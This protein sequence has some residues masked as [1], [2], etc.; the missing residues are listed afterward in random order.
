[1]IKTVIFDFDG[2]IADTWEVIIKLLK[3]HRENLGLPE[4]TAEIVSDFRSKG[5][6]E[7]ILKYNFILL[8]LPFI[9]PKVQRML[10]DHIKEVKLFPEMKN[11]LNSLKSRGNK[12]GIL[13]T[14]TKE[15][16]ETFL[17]FHEINFFD[18]I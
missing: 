4:I 8:K 12:I 7:L 14:N 5:F 1:M 15:N 11:L 17:R 18:F 2:T 6:R 9:I 16:V 10:N 3:K 13:T